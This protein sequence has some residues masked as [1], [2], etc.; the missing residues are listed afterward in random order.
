V[1]QSVA[2][3]LINRN[4]ALLWGGS[5]ISLIG[6]L[7]F[8]TTLV[9][10]IATSV[11]HGA[12]WAPLAV[13]GV[14]LATFIPSTVAGPFAGV[15][16][17]RWNKRHT[18]MAMDGI[19]AVLVVLL[20]LITRLVPVPFL[21][22]GQPPV[23]WL[24]GATYAIVAAASICSSFATPASFAFLGSLVSEPQRTIAAARLE[25]NNS[26]SI[27]IGPSLAAILFG[28]GPAL[29]LGLNALSFVVSFAAVL[30]IRPPASITARE[31][32]PH[33]SFLHEAAAGL[34][35]FA[36]NRLLVTITVATMVA[37]VGGSALNTLNVFFITENLHSPARLYGVLGAALGAGSII[38]ALFMALVIG[39][40]GS[41][42][43]FWASLLIIGVIVVVYSRL[44]SF[45]AATV[46]FFLFGLPNS[47]L[48]VA[49][50]PLLLRT[51]PPAM[52]GRV[53]SLFGPLLATARLASAVLAG[54]L[55]SGVL[56]G[57]H[58]NVLGITF[59]S[60]DSIFAASG[61]LC[62][63]AALYAAWQ[64]RSE[65]ESSPSPEASAVETGTLA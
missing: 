65:T 12:S 46:L 7:L 37:L 9:L 11:A 39:R 3:L 13:S 41:V 32:G 59:G 44:S 61:V 5:G 2:R 6:D 62:I 63:V 64:L 56:S 23:A 24:L 58:V 4:F 40:V 30:A 26:L 1:L 8:D 18:M 19:R 47:A 33:A 28:L 45:A 52:L 27:V 35:F 15:F 55:A 57:L 16:V 25:V 34:R 20:L 36:T 60:I 31:G 22:G 51:V 53:M 49:I 14:F 42:R 50:G 10:W 43:A 48:N 38:G 17:D 21:P 29:A 54:Y